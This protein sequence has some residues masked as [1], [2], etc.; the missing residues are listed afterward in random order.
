MLSRRKA[1]TATDRTGAARVVTAGLVLACWLGLPP[2]EMAAG[3]PAAHSP[4]RPAPVPGS[5]ERRAAAGPGTLAFAG[6]GG[7]TGEVPEASPVAGFRIDREDSWVVAVTETAGLFGFLGHRHAIEVTDWKA[8]ME[9]HPDRL[10][11]SRAGVTVP[12]TALRID[13]ARSRDLAGLG[14]G[15]DEE[16][17]AELQDKMLGPE[18]LAAAEHPELRLELT[19][20]SGDPA[21]E[22]RVAGELTVRGRTEPIRFPVRVERRDGDGW[23]FTGSF[24]VRQSAFGIEPESVGGVVNVA[25][26]VEIRFRVAVAR[27]EG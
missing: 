19:E 6:R 17:V 2:V 5:E 18:N 27:T 26:P 23:L 22:L 14:G 3:A 24:T 12:A 25:D 16:T 10:A 20:V 11:A 9:W 8:R 21:E 4:A 13:T 1:K 15:P 7:E